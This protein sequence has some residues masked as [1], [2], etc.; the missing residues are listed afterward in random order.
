MRRRFIEL[1]AALAVCSAPPA[2]AQARAH[3]SHDVANSSSDA[4]D[5]FMRRAREGTD[6]Y[7][8]QGVAV[9]DGYRRLGPDFPAMGEHW[10]NPELVAKGVFDP[11]R[12]GL[13]TYVRVNGA[14][15]LTGV[16]YAIPLDEGELPPHSPFDRSHWHDHLG[17]IDEESMLLSHD[18][19]ASAPAA[20]M[21]LAVLH[22]WTRV[23]NPAGSSVTD[24]WALPY[25][26]LGLPAPRSATIGAARALS[27]LSGSVSYYSAL[28][29]TAASPGVDDQRRIDVELERGA[30]RVR[31]WWN[32]RASTAALSPSETARLEDEWSSIWRSA[33]QV[34][35][36]EAAR[37][38][39]AVWRP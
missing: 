39:G 33:E 10:A 7:R 25:V 5:A 38:L 17:S 29:R 6:R 9:E 27:L 8:D 22:L 26:R 13:L 35:A 3:P 18:S 30:E 28:A 20:A 16:V 31:A 14:P 19:R 11:A 15:M 34:V 36:P 21:R 12:P 4:V 1:L 32:G 2:R 23:E 37:R 24:N